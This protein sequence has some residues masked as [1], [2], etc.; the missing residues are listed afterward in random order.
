MARQCPSCYKL[1]GLEMQDPEVNDITY[2]EDSQTITVDVRIV[3]VSACCNDEM[4]DYTFNVDTELP[5]DLVATMAKVKKEHPDVD[6]DAQEGSVDQLE[7]GGSRYKKSYF[8]F[9]L[10]VEIGYNLPSRPRTKA[11]QE[12]LDKLTS[13]YTTTNA[14]TALRARRSDLFAIG[15]PEWKVIGSVEVTDKIEA[16]GMDE[17]T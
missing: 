2:D 10:N 9:T 6:F 1:C 11:E 13:D 14:S 4:K 3:R 12:E 5:D 15:K 8:G 7:E 17:L 16:S